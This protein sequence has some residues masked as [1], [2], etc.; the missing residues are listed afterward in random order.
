M[1]TTVDT[2]R[3]KAGADLRD[4]AG[5]Y[6]S[7]RH[8]SRR[9]LSGPCPKCGGEDRFHVTA[10]MAFGRQCWPLERRTPAH[11]AIGLVQWLGL[12]QGFRAAAAYLDASA[13]R[14]ARLR[15]PAP[16]TSAHG[17]QPA[18]WQEEA[19]RE[20]VEAQVCLEEAAGEPARDYLRMRGLHPET[21]RAWGLGSGRGWDGLAEQRRPAILLPWQRDRIT[22]LKYRFID[23]L[24]G[25]LR[26]TS[27]K[28]GECI[29]FGLGLA[30][31][32]RHAL[33]LIE[34]EINALSLWQALG[35]AGCVNAD[36]VSFGGES[37]AT[38]PAILGLTRRYRQVI[39]W[40]D[41]PGQAQAAM[42]AVP[43]AFGLR[44]PLVE[45]AKLDANALLQRGGLADFAWAAW[46]G[47]D[48]DPAYVARFRAELGA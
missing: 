28:G 37:G 1:K 38:S 29:A 7:L 32:H 4:L 48:Q 44:S 19:R 24:E 25:G 34:G 5:R 20:L 12:A 15:E 39:V 13:L 35:G 31:S 21:W 30:G 16:K 6:A 11:D 9:E 23:R 3:M 10:D 33:W 46:E 26:Y 45:G 40:A 27:K 22:A 47:F 41:D 17:W 2:A 42:R 8:E 18:G 36:V 43:G 14:A